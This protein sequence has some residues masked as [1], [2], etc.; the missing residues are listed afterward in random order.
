MHNHKKSGAREQAILRKVG[1]VCK[2]KL[3]AG[4]FAV[5]PR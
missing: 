1:F 5:S 3:S 4:K 2:L